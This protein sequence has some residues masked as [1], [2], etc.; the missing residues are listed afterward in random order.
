[1][2]TKKVSKTSK[3]AVQ[4]DAIAAAAIIADQLIQATA[5]STV[6]GE[7]TAAINAQCKAMRAA[8]VSIGKSRRTCP[9]SA[10]IYDRMPAS[11][12]NGTKSNY[13]TAIRTAVNEGKDFKFPNGSDKKAGKKTG[14][15]TGGT[16]TIMIALSAGDK[17]EA[18][19]NKL[20]KG[21][22][23]MR[24]ALLFR[25]FMTRT[26]ATPN[27]HRHSRKTGHGFTHHTQSVFKR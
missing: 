15:K 5:A 11:L 19:A 6:L 2:T 3:P 21:F 22:E 14:A 18:A 9:I 17:P 23:K 4:F 12:A 25:A 20:R 8:K 10:A 24:E 1:M 26:R 16:G 27:T 13:L 7:A